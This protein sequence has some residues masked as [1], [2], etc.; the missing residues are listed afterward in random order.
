VIA[1]V[2]F[3][4][5]PADT[6]PQIVALGAA[7]RPVRCASVLKPLYF[8][9]AASLPDSGDQAA[10]ARLAEPAVTRSANQPT[11][12]IWERCGPAALLDGIGRLTGVRWRS[13]PTAPRSFGRVLVTADGLARAFAALAVAA[14]ADDPIATQL[15]GWMRAVPERQTFGA[16]AAAAER[17]AVAPEHVAVKTGWFIDA[18]ETAL[19]T[20]AVTISLTPD[21]TARG[22]AVLTALSVSEA[23][24][25][26]HAATYLHGDEVLPIHWEH[27]AE[28]I[29]RTTTALL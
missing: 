19:R 9:A 29:R 23:V 5:L 3:T 17:L 18:D 24:R 4:V 28:T 26:H 14:R 12:T 6:E 20:H 7:D 1:G 2:G 25:T 22:T 21:G 15:L 16:R 27:A 11:V 10:W 8:W 13:D